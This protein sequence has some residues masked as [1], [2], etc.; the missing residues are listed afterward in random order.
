MRLFVSSSILII[1]LILNKNVFSLSNDHKLSILKK[2]L[3]QP[4]SISF[5]NK[6][7]I[8]SNQKKNKFQ[9]MPA[10]FGL[11]P[12]LNKKIKDKKLRY[13]AYHERSLEVLKGFKKILDSSFEKEQLLMK[14]N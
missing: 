5:I 13:K 4:W 14:I 9:P 10:S 1:F 12:E 11:F 7:E 3:D 6:N 2:D 8:L